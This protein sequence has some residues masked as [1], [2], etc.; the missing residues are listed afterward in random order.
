[1]ALNGG[2]PNYRG[3]LH[4][5]P[6][7][8]VSLT[9]KN[10]KEFWGRL[11]ATIPNALVTQKNEVDMKLSLVTGGSVECW[12]FEKFSAARGRAYAGIVL[13]EAAITPDLQEAW[14]EVFQAMLLDYKGWAVLGSSP[15]GFNHFHTMYGY[16][17][18]ED[19]TEWSSFHYTSYDN[20]YIDNAEI[21]KLKKT[22][23]DDTFKREYL[24]EFTAGGGGVFKFKDDTFDAPMPAKYQEGHVYTMGIDWGQSD[25]STVASIF[26]ATDY[27][28]VDMLRLS[29]L[30]YLVMIDKIVQLAFAWRVEKIFPEANAMSTNIEILAAELSKLEWPIDSRTKYPS[31]PT[32]QKVWMDIRKKGIL[33]NQMITGI[34]LGLKLQNIP[35]A[36]HE[37]KAYSSVQREASGLW[38]YSHP[39]GGHDDTVIARLLA[40]AATY[41]LKA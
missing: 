16:G 34:E 18:N 24:A 35:V 5:L 36:N 40:H 2:A 6:I 10:V 7:A 27:C 28:E 41:E 19:L 38:T 11:K 13:D 37:M 15:N 26:D 39:S 30:E 4:G 14:E 12:T 21:D 3:A 23:A 22:I 1:M 8:Y 33:V 32:I 31:N 25:D 17:L 29:K 20:P 9:Y